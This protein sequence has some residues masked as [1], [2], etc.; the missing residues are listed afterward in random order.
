M[1]AKFVISDPENP[2]GRIFSKIENFRKNVDTYPGNTNMGKLQFR[3]LI[4]F[5]TSQ[6]TFMRPINF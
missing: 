6:P 2:R 4:E 1:D 3:H 5:Y